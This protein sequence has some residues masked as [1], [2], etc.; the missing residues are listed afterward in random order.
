MSVKPRL[1]SWPS[2][3]GGEWCSEPDAFRNKTPGYEVVWGG[4]GKASTARLQ[5]IHLSQKTA[6]RQKNKMTWILY[7]SLS[8]YRLGRGQEER[9]HG[10]A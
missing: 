5:M 9:V 6:I 4:G 7:P 1:S 3:F 10:W 8:R 2:L